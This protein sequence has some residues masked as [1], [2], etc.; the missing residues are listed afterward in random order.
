MRTNVN[1]FPP[2]SSLRVLI[3]MLVRSD[4]T[5]EPSLR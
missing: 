3:A 5:G 2:D 1:A 4:S